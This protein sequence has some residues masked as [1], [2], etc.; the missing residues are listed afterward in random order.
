M[1]E[2]F[3]PVPGRSGLAAVRV[4]V[5]P[6]TGRL[7]DPADPGLLG[8]LEGGVQLGY[9]VVPVTSA[10]G[11]DP[12]GEVEDRIDPWSLPFGGEPPGPGF[13]VQQW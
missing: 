10:K 1:P 8:Q 7:R 9:G 2:R 12:G 13:G 5:G 11:D 6:D 3:E 4:D